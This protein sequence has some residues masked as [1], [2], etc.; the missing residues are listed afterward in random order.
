MKSFRFKWN[1]L[2][3]EKNNWQEEMSGSCEMN[4]RWQEYNEMFLKGETDFLFC[5]KY[6]YIMRDL[7]FGLT[8]PP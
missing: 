6:D 7:M 3:L 5:V 8:Q 4:S 2:E 1:E